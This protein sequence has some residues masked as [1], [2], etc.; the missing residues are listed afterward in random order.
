MAKKH[1]THQNKSFLHQERYF[2]RN[3]KTDITLRDMLEKVVDLEEITNVIVA[4][5]NLI[6]S[7]MALAS[8][9]IVM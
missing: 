7:K 1:Q 2:K 8:L 5:S 6:L 3:K 9:F 4:Q